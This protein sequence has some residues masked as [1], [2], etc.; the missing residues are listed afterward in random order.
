MHK[1]IA[2]AV[3]SSLMAASMVASSVAALVP[4]S[5][6]AGNCLGQN[7]FDDGVGLPWHICV[8]N[9]AEQKFDMKGGTYNCTIVN[10]G[11]EKRGGDSRWDC[12]FRHR[13]LHIEK[14]HHYTIHWE[15]DASSAGELHTH[16]H[17]LSGSGDGAWQDNAEQWDKG[18]DN[19]K[20]SKG[21]NEF[22]SE[23]T[24][25]ETLEVAEWAF[26]Y[27]GAG[28]YQTQDCFPEGTTLKFDN[29]KLECSDC[30]DTYKDEKSTPCL[31]DPS[32]ELGVVTPRSDVRINQ[33]GY[34][35]NARKLATY[36][37][38]D[39][40]SAVSFTVKKN[41]T[42][43]Y[44]GT[45]KVIGMDKDAGDYCQILDFSEVKEP[46]TYTIEVDDTSNTFLNPKTKET[47][48]KYI[49][50]EFKIGDDVYEGIV[51]DA[52][53]YF[54][55]NRSGMDI[56]SAYITSHNEKDDAKKLAHQGGHYPND[57]AYVQPKWQ[58]SY[59]QEFDG[60]TS[61]TVDCVGGWYDAGDHGKYVVNGGIS[62]WTLQN[63]YERSKVQGTDAKWADGKTMLIPQ[64]YSVGNI[65]FDGTGSPD[66]LDEARVELEWM[67]NMIVTSKDKHWGSKCE[68]LVYHK[69]H[70]H[71][72]TGL[73]TKPWDYA[74]EK[75]ADGSDG[76]NTTR[77][78]KPPTYAAT[79]N[80]IACAAQA[81]RLW[82]GIDDSFSAKCL[83]KAETSWKAMMAKKSSW[84][85]VDLGKD[86]WEKDP[87]FAPLD[88]AI[89]GGGYG[90]TYVDD[91]AYWA[92][93][94]LFSTTG[95]EEYYNFLKDYK[96]I[97]EG[98]GHDKAFDITTSLGGGENNGSFSS[99]NW[100]CTAGLGTV[101]L[102]LSDKVSAEDK[103][104][105][106]ANIKKCADTYVAFEDGATNGMGIPY[107]GTTFTDD[108]NCPGETIEGYEWGSNSFV[109]NNAVVMAYAYD[110]TKDTTYMN[111]V[112]TALDYIFGR[113]GLG[114]SF[115]T[116]YGSYHSNN[117]HHRYWSY[118]LDHDFPMAPA[119]VMS[120]GCGAGLQD[121]YVGGLGYQ[122][123]KTASQKCFVD[124]IEAWSV[125]EVTI[126]WNAPFAW[127][128]AFFDD[129]A[130]LFPKGDVQTTTT[131]TTTTAP[132]TT[133]TTQGGGDVTV[134]LWGDANCDGTVDLADAI[135][136]MQSLANPNK[137]GI[138][139]TAAKP[140]T[141]QGQANADVD[142]STKGLTGDDAVK[143]QEYL[144]K[145]IAS[146]DPTKA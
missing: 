90:D 123:G 121:P 14:G 144:L 13:S 59:G 64:S 62:V 92:A 57:N 68:N 63:M 56:E 85:G 28:P 86:A 42:A 134:T 21:K 66:V 88:Q 53:N 89:G 110:I 11:G 9:P 46:G 47:Y 72:W 105:V 84:Y 124:S 100:G 22:D 112:T 83:E 107:K 24:A 71:K 111:G 3:T 18:W 78:V 65:K 43:V 129:E 128:M 20:I 32:N 31:W 104:T 16:I 33:V 102:L 61:V 118:E 60:D 97:H 87:Q 91:D 73:A 7:D 126:N 55:Q 1:K 114:F 49:S 103:A 135:L 76:W 94:E 96:N 6:S 58:K 127:A 106:E 15:V 29:M 108:I 142:T 26:H 113:N 27:G 137:Y 37:T 44:T 48:K 67:F 50:H 81:S 98:D 8:T 93:C 45:G 80:M 4:M 130:P 12:Q 77:I 40:K 145:K 146:L 122:R 119:G 82:K 36:A 109:I 141:K 38:S 74:G 132:I 10:P 5:A 70:D 140:L 25:K 23:F 34:F 136:I 125:N 99:F 19:V 101:T 69:M 17:R 41:G 133:T 139:G 143:I 117:P 30:G 120:G 95:D 54:Y 116:G 138:G 52:M 75:L 2:K 51:K 39:S 79:L 35:T 131:T 115:V